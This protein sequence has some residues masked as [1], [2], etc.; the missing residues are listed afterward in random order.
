MRR[1]S[2]YVVRK[3]TVD[4]TGGT[5]IETAINDAISLSA[6]ERA[7]VEFVF[8]DRKVLVSTEDLARK[9][10]LEWSGK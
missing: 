5:R 8:N 6:Q 4:F 1:M 3:L 10:Y 9:L 7:E 2:K